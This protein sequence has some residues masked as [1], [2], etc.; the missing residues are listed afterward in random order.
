MAM[1]V[2]PDLWEVKPPLDGCGNLRQVKENI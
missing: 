1:K 2:I